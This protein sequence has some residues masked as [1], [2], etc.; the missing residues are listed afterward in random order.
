M[1]VPDQAQ[2]QAPVMPATQDAGGAQS[3]GPGPEG[4]EAQPAGEPSRHPLMRLGSR[5]H[6]TTVTVSDWQK[7][8]GRRCM[9]SREPG[10]AKQGDGLAGSL[11]EVFADEQAVSSS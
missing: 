4:A 2:A 5:A 10:C 3:A 6:V 11:P 9:L 7:V 8:F 1:Q